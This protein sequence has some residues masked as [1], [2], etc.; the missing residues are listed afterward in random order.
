[1]PTF[2]GDEICHVNG[3]KYAFNIVLTTLIAKFQKILGFSLSRK[4]QIINF[5]RKKFNNIHKLLI[6]A[7]K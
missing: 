5:D 6:Q 1:M 2:Y 4:Y 3:L 7:K